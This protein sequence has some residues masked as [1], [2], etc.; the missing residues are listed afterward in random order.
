MQVEKF[1]RQLKSLSF[2][3]SFNPY[4]DRCTVYDYFDAPQKRRSMLR[5]MLGAATQVE[6]DS[7][8]IGR[9]LGYR[10]GRRTGLAL[11]DDVHLAH[12]TKRWGIEIDRITKGKAVPERTASVIWDVLSLIETPIFLWNVFPL[13]PYEVGKQFSNRAHNSIERAAGE[14]LLEALIGILNPRR[15]VAIGNDAEKAALRMSTREKIVKV[16]H[17]SYGGQNEFLAQM[18]CLYNIG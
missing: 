1:I 12:H 18:K 7:I 5:A 17:P 16:R 8:W 14:E 9:D 4:S 2:E 11:T 10:G 15:I 13:H 3:N 6:I